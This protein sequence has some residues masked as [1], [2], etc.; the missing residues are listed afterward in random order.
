MYV[1]KGPTT[2]QKMSGIFLSNK[3]VDYHSLQQNQSSITTDWHNYQ[4]FKPTRQQ[5][6]HIGIG[7]IFASWVI[8]WIGQFFANVDQIF[9]RLHKVI[10][11]MSW[12]TFWALFHQLIWP[13]CSSTVEPA[14]IR[15]NLKQENRQILVHHFRRASSIAKQRLRENVVSSPEDKSLICFRA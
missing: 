2:T 13:P 12:A 3:I 11:Q 9:P 4:S 5:G 10:Y 6:D 7:R 15:Q 8:V 1:H 14:C